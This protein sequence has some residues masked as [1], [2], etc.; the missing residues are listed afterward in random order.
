[1]GSV[2][3][4]EPVVRQGSARNACREDTG[5][6]GHGRRAR[7]ARPRSRGPRH[8]DLALGVAHD[9]AVVAGEAPDRSRRTMIAEPLRSSAR[10]CP[11]C[12]GGR[13][14]PRSRTVY[15]QRVR[16]PAADSPVTITTA[17]SMIVGDTSV[18][19]EPPPGR[20]PT[21]RACR[22]A[23]RSGD[24][25]TR[26]RLAGVAA[27]RSAIGRLVL[28]R[29]AR[30]CLGA[31][32]LARH[33]GTPAQAEHGD[34]RRSDGRDRRDGPD[35]PRGVPAMTRVRARCTDGAPRGPPARERASAGAAANASTAAAASSSSAS[36][37]Q[38]AHHCRC[39]ST[40]TASPAPRVPSARSGS[41]SRTAAQFTRLL[42]FVRAAHLDHGRAQPGLHRAERDAVGL[43][44]LARR[45][46][47]GST[48]GRAAGARRR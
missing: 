19:A 20:R 34:H 37:R 15:G 17:M 12:S 7:R 6:D 14:G 43:G 41:R 10:S 2:R 45:E 33:H 5:R 24:R 48:R 30:L 32:R 4:R 36:L 38:A 9:D 44:D 39:R 11:T 46:A 23:P 18:S 3:E 31:R 26:Q 29:P 40:A 13:R 42:A 27:N 25:R 28:G 47:R 1:M 21:A 35:A 22:S 8:H 16:P